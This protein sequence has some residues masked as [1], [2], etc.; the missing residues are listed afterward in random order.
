MNIYSRHEDASDEGD[1]EE[2][3]DLG[4][5]AG[6]TV[7][8]G[9][10]HHQRDVVEVPAVVQWARAAVARSGALLRC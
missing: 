1:E 4:E 5:G 8:N 9:D 10:Q 3:V 6:T 7:R 2:R